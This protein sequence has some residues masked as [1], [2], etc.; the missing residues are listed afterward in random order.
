MASLRNEAEGSARFC[1]AGSI[2]R[3]AIRA[4]GDRNPDSLEN[5][6][7]VLV[8]GRRN[9]TIIRP[10]RENRLLFGEDP[11]KREDEGVLGGRAPAAE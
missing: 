4:L 7:S 3:A 1:E 10:Q 5:E 2:G 11:G 9:R 8:R 6:L